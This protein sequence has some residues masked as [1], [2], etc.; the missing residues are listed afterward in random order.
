[1]SEL[2]VLTTEEMYAKGWHPVWQWD[3]NGNAAAVSQVDWEAWKKQERCPEAQSFMGRPTQC[4]Q[5]RGHGGDHTL[6]WLD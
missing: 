4:G 3:E 1:M 2:R 6:E 5:L